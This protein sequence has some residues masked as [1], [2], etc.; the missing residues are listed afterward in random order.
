[1]IEVRDLARHYT[2]QAGLMD[3]L[4]GRQPLRLRAVDGVSFD[5]APGEV[6]GLVGE[7]GCGKST[8]GRLLVG[9]EEP[10]AGSV[11]IGSEDA[12]ALRR[13]DRRA[14]HRRV[15]MVFQDP[16]G[17]L[18]PYLTISEIIARPLIYQ[19]HKRGPDLYARVTVALEQAGLTPAAQFLTRHPHQLSGG[20]RQRVCIARAIVL[21][22]SVLVAD[23]PISMLDVSI[24]WGIIRLLKRLVA[25]RNISLLYIT[26]D[27]ATVGAICDRI[28]IM[29]LG[30]IVEIGPVDQVLA[31]PR[32]PYTAALV[33]AIPVAVPGGKR[34]PP[35]ISG[36][37]P[38]AAQIPPGCRFAP[39]CPRASD[40]CRSTEPT[41]TGSSRW[42]VACHHPATG[43]T[44]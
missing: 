33:S 32:H 42:H 10:A 7:S 43:A 27:L 44:A 15:Q 1:M 2:M 40:L 14:F 34:P 12:M 18:N 23:E 25:E 21:D 13:T 30:R 6:L 29:Y 11:R 26:H 41:M 24:K 20:Q 22:P 36:A 31:A 38:D 4:R 35:E 3:R 37:I 19:G 17:S 8:T 5:L 16:Y 28:A 9:L 39:R